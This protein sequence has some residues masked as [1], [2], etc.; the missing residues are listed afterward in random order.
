MSEQPDT[1]YGR[2]LDLCEDIIDVNA[3]NRSLNDILDE[4]VCH[5]KHSLI[6]N[7][8]ITNRLFVMNDTE[9][10]NHL[11]KPVKSFKTH[12]DLTLIGSPQWIIIS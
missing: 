5:N 3:S 2:I 6:D 1:F 12:Q 8:P 4:T 7:K 10:F 11:L 9:C